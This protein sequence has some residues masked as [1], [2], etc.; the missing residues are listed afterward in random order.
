MANVNDVILNKNILIDDSFVLLD[1][2]EWDYLEYNDDIII[3]KT[4]NSMGKYYYKSMNGNYLI[5]SNLKFNTNNKKYKYIPFRFSKTNILHIYRQSKIY[6]NLDLME[7][8]N[9]ISSLERENKNLKKKINEII[10]ILKDSNSSI[11]S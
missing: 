1:N 7:M 6:C 5:C 3:E 9:K 10:K 11:C 8:N 2:N 4:D